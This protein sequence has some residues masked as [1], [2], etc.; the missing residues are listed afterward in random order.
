VGDANQIHQVLMNLAINA[1][2]AMPRGGTLTLTVSHA[3]LDADY[4]RSHPLAHTGPHLVIA[5]ADTGTGMTPE[6][7]ARAFEPFF[8]TKPVGKGT[9]LGLASVYGI[10]QNHTGHIELESSVGEGTEVRVY[11]PAVDKPD[12]QD[13]HSMEPSEMPKGTARVLL[14]DDEPAILEIA[15]ALLGRLGY[16]VVTASDGAEAIAL[17]RERWREID[18]VMLDMSMPV[19]D[20]REAARE[21]LALNPHCRI[22]LASGRDPDDA[23]NDLMRS[24]GVRFVQKPFRARHLADAVRELLG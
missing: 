24:A 19:L 13:G 8:T 20:G 21:L 12:A 14:V 10:V 6:V 11:L 4:V 22:L 5:V 1:R 9:G 23:M 15:T 17:Y 16:E 2:D 7:R 18:L 3:D